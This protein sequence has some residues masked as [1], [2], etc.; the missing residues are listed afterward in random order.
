MRPERR[1]EPAEDVSQLVEHEMGR[2]AQ[3]QGPPDP[4]RN[5]DPQRDR[6]EER[7]AEGP[8][9]GDETQIGAAPSRYHDHRVVER[10]VDQVREHGAEQEPAELLGS[11]AARREKA[12]DAEMPEDEHVL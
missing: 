4:P 3:E 1:N 7:V 9:A 6:E 11:N 5:D 8:R 12:S 2:N 10:L